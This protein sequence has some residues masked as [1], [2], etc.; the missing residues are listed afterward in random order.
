MLRP[1]AGE[2]CG[3]AAGRRLRRKEVMQTVPLQLRPIAAKLGDVPRAVTHRAPGTFPGQPGPPQSPR[4]AWSSLVSWLAAFQSSIKSF[5]QP[6]SF[7]P[8]SIQNLAISGLRV[9]MEGERP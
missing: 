2:K 9:W 1:S 6:T 5:P 7:I 4:A 8:R 3:L